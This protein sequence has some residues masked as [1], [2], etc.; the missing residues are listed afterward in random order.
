MLPRAIKYKLFE[1]FPNIGFVP[2]LACTVYTHPLQQ[3]NKFHMQRQVVELLLL[4]FIILYMTLLTSGHHK[5]VQ[6]N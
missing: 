2:S 5:Y 6:L 3:N 1:I 4:T